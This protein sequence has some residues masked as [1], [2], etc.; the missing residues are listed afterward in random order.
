MNPF[1]FG[2]VFWGD[3]FRNYFLDYCLSS[4]LAPRNI[5]ALENKTANRFLICT[6]ADDWEKMQGHPIFYLLKNETQPVFLDLDRLEPSHDKMQFMSRGHKAIA[7]KMHE[8]CAYGTFI[9]PDT[10]FSDGVV[11]QLQRLAGQGKKVVV[12]HCPR[13]A[14]EGFLEQLQ[15]KN[16][17]QVGCPLSL[18][19]QEL[20]R[21]AM[22]H[23]HSETRRYE[24]EAP[25]FHG[26]MPALIW[27]RVD[28]ESLVVHS[29]TW[30]PLLFDYAKVKMHDTKTL[31]NWTID[32]DYIYKNI[33]S[34]DEVHVETDPAVMT[35]I[36][37]TPEASLTY[38]P[39]KPKLLMRLPVFGSWYR[40]LCLRNVLHAP[41]VDPLKRQLF[42]SPV[43]IPEM[44]AEEKVKGLNCKIEQIFQDCTIP[45]SDFEQRMFYWLR[46]LNEGIGQHLGY[47]L[48][49]RPSLKRLLGKLI[50]ST[51]ML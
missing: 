42:H 1:Y 18:Q 33:T 39:L 35:L 11:A 27:W 6:T 28:R 4:L 8:D 12:A 9:Y 51:L 16:L 36:S 13:F 2:V 49:R 43:Y 20:L 17:I 3:E 15:S 26:E 45:L 32:G 7:C 38:L 41:Q 29:F 47:W 50:K 46:I 19:G 48:A 22:P 40:K 24:W 31:E 44:L 23:M 30:A 10:I 14:N 21:L 37:F 34:L 25:Y 5:P